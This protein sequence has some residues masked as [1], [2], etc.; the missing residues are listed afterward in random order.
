VRLH[1]YYSERIVGRL[2]VLRPMAALAGMHHERLD[3]SG[4]HRGS[5]RADIP[6]GARVLAAAD[7]YQAM[8]QPRA[9][10]PAL[11]PA[12]AAQEL[13]TMASSGRLDRDAVS[14]VLAAAG[15]VAHQRQARRPERLRH[16]GRARASA[17][18]PLSQTW[19]LI[20][21]ETGA[22]TFQRRPGGVACRGHRFGRAVGRRFSR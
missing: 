5:P 17:S 15:Y 8:T 6:P 16:V 7:A 14:S 4:H 11:E 3:G 10:R 21:G 2:Q 9:H 22:D 20:G 13:E 12:R 18:P 19:A 1:P